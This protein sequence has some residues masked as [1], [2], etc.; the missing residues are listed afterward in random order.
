MAISVDGNSLI[1]NNCTLTLSNAFDPTTGIATITITP[2]GGLGTLPALVNG[3]PGLPP[4]INIGTVTTLA[5]NA[6]ATA[7]L[8]LVTAGGAGTASTYN[9]NLGIPAGSPGSTGSY[10]IAAA[11][12]YAAGSNSTN[13]TSAPYSSG[14]YSLLN[15]YTLVYNSST[16]KWNPMPPPLAGVYYATSINSTSGTGAGPRN[17]T[18]IVVPAQN[19]PYFP[20][21]SGQTIVNGTVNTQV[22]LQAFITNSSG[23]QVGIGYSAAGTANQ[24]VTLVPSVP[25]G[26][27]STYGQVAAG[28][29]A[30]IILYATQVAST[31]DAWTTSASTTSFQ[32]AALPV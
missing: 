7:S 12:D 26:S 24:V 9:L 30:T 32:V 6:S 17:L 4:V 29:T 25:T 11:T 3:T 20:M 23:Q 21:V 27:S 18:S 13:V 5:Y 19:Y 1:I 14:T 31:T 16:S 28:S 10:T 22:N 8:S 15:G 2:S